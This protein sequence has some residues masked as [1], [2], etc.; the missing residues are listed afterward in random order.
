MPA[1]VLTAVFGFVAAL[2]APA[3]PIEAADYRGMT[4]GWPSYANG[5]YAANYPANYAAGPAY[6][7][8][9]PVAAGYAAPA[10]GA[11]YR[12]VQATYANPAYFAAYGRSPVAYRPVSAAGYAPA[13][14]GY[15]A[16]TT[17]YYA[18][19][20]ANYAPSNSYAVSPAGLGSAGSEAAAYFGQPTPLNYVP[21]QFSYRPTYAA[22]PVYMY[23][24][25]TTYNPV[26][27]QPQTCLQASTSN[28]CQPTRTRCG[29]WLNP[30]NWFSRGSSCGSGGCGPAPTTA[31]CGT[32]C[33]QQP[34]YPAQPM[35]PVVPVVPAPVTA[36][37]ANTFP[38]F[39]RTIQSQ[40]TVP[41]PPTVAPG[42]RTI[43]NPVNPG[44]P[45]D[46]QP[47]LAPRTTTPLPSSVTP[48]P[49]TTIPGG[50]APGGSFPTAPGTTQPGGFGAPSFGTG[51]NYA[52]ATDP[53]AASSPMTPANGGARN[54]NIEKEKEKEP[55]H[56][57]F[58]SGYRG[59]TP[60]AAAPSRSTG[61]DI[62]VIRAP[63]LAPALPPNVQTVPDLD[64]P[65][66]PKPVNS[67]PQLLNPR[68]KTASRDSRWAVVPAKWPQRQTASNQLR[69]RPVVQTKSHQPSVSAAPAKSPYLQ[70]VSAPKYDDG[71]WKSAAF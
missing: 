71:G 22:V 59:Q 67:A 33:G 49:S 12:P 51:T 42:T 24:P 41:P 31:Y 63:D 40:P 14:G 30:F 60:A 34:Y 17:A 62:Q 44:V 15:Y 55:A 37:P 61:N 5:Y 11:M 70:P 9:R 54:S 48:L 27:A 43:I 68:D 66:T 50:T 47:S 69:D 8:A 1:R 26:T 57:V 64:A 25:V 36:A 29:S 45:A 3:T 16:P 10:T 2:L 23:R 21:P 53:Y 20:T 58:G 28:T 65:Q 46:F 52:P 35:T 18:P 6:Y 39:P 32:G 19:V 13:A 7:V 4:A 56:S 38:I